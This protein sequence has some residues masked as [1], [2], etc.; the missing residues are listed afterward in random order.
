MHCSMS[1]RPDAR[2][3]EKCK[4]KMKRLYTKLDGKYAGIANGCV[5]CGHFV[6]DGQETAFDKAWQVIL[7][8]GQ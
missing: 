7:R 2:I 8:G 5:R 3:C 1:P 4:S 6:W